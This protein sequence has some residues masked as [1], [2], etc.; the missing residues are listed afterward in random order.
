[1]SE[2][3][4]R[5]NRRRF[6]TTVGGGGVA[7]A[8]G[9]LSFD[10]E[11]GD[12]TWGGAAGERIEVVVRFPP[13]DGD[14][15]D[16]GASLATRLRRHAADAQATFLDA[17]ADQT[18][19]TVERRFWLA[20][21]VVVS[22]DPRHV[23]PADLAAT[24]GV[25]DVHP[26]YATARPPDERGGA[27][28]DRS[29]RSSA[30]AVAGSGRTTSMVGSAPS[31]PDGAETTATASST[32]GPGTAVRAS[33]AS[34]SE[35]E[36]APGVEAL[37]ADAVW[38]FYDVRGAGVDVAVLD[39]GVDPSGHDGIADA[40]ERGGWAEFDGSGERVESDPHDPD[41][42]GTAV[43]GIVAG[44][45]TDDGVRYGVAPEAALH[46]AKVA[47]DE[48]RFG[49][50]V[51]SLEWAIERGVDVVSIG[52][53]PFRYAASLVEPVANARESGAVVVGAVG[54]AGRY[55]STTPGNLEPVI[56]VGAVDADGEVAPS[57]GGETV[58]TDR[59]WES[60][61]PDAW[62]EEYH[63]PDVT[64]VGVDVPIAEPEG[65]YS[66]AAGTGYAAA[67]VAG[68][69]ALAVAAA[70][71]P[72]GT[73][74]EDALVDSAVHP[75]REDPFALDPG[76]DDRYGAGIASAFLAASALLA[77]ETVSG[78]VTD[79]N[80]RPLPDVEV[81]AEAGPSTTT[82]AEG[83][84]TLV[85]PPGPQPVGAHGVGYD[86]DVTELD[87]ATT[88][89]WD[90]QL[91]LS[92]AIE[93]AVVEGPPTRIAP[94]E[95]A[96]AT[97]TVANVET[98]S[99][100]VE[101]EYFLDE[102]VL[103]LAIDGEPAAFGDPTPVADGNPARNLEI[104]VATG[105][106]VPP[107]RFELSVAVEGTGDAVAGEIGPVYVHPDPW[108]L[109]TDAGP[110]LQD[111]VGLVAPGTT[112]EL[113]GEEFWMPIEEGD[114]AGLVIDRPVSLVGE[115]DGPRIQ[116]DGAEN[117][118]RPGVLVAANDVEI[119][120]LEVAAFDAAA[121]IQVGTDP[122]GPE[123]AAPSGVTIHDAI[124]LGA[125]DGIVARTAPALHVQGT[126]V[127]A[128]DV[129]ISVQG[130]QRTTLEG[131][132][133]HDVGVGIEVDG[134]TTRLAKNEVANVED[135]GILVTSSTEAVDDLA[136]SAEPIRENAVANA[137][138]GIV[139]DGATDAPIEDNRLTNVEEAAIAI[140]G[141]VLGAIRSNH[142]EGAAT[143]VHVGPDAT[144]GEIADNVFEN[145]DVAV[146]EDDGQ[147]VGSSAL[148]L[149]LY[150]LTAATL[151]VLVLPNVRRRLGRWRS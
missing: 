40:L 109:T 111:A 42:H 94:G 11:N 110:S 125:A 7:A 119:A 79:S 15:P 9:C 115:G 2:F 1:M 46:H 55:A 95:H 61:A 82:D 126:D 30:T 13:A 118:D 77:E 37:H 43:S 64:A 44:D 5:P 145:V 32:S 112:L 45:A 121:A 135:A 12:G 53:G 149:A 96:S 150:G 52:L 140:D 35:G 102:H 151:G 136:V 104:T 142:V 67:H 62:P 51:A 141:D 21:A 73:A 147:D 124:V 122:Q 65:G 24:E 47:A 108:T 14:R 39:T 38:D 87:P 28:V 50:V 17:V 107:G 49:A 29:A 134:L 36:V 58:R 66:R 71:D 72:D 70:D 117:P 56:G 23:S 105:T 129:G 133:V 74:V 19:V 16:G 10:G 4:A 130:L 80:G 83:R 54:D 41:G 138:R 97:I 68:A 33:F 59:Y 85:L 128:D 89:Q 22:I 25:R 8:A 139:V 57:S 84:Y 78:T 92:E 76:H 86:F 123:T 98:V 81:L 27:D 146:L 6:L 20:D 18:G 114:R 48:V 144:T 26:N 69:A 88:S 101:T 116:F 60:S 99:V 103:E 93:T 34:A 120:A 3:T 31:P 100:T 143:G 91:S 127:T 63:V 106:E 148:D 75:D 132:G 131:N 113:R 137:R 90:P